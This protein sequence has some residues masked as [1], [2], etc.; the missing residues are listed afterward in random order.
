MGLYFDDV[1]TDKSEEI[2]RLHDL[3]RV[4]IPNTI[5]NKVEALTDE[6]RRMINNHTIYARDAVRAVY[7]FPY[8]GRLLE[9]Y[10][11]IALYH[12]E[13]YDGTGYPEGLAGE[14][15]PYEAR[16]CAVADVY[17]GITSWKPYK[18]KQTT[19]EQAGEIILSEAGRQFDPQLAEL[20]VKMI[21]RL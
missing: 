19:K 13:R 16:I 15:I 20:F 4:Y 21:P 2:F 9:Q 8:E 12:H 7:D 17:D 6:E 14:Y 11:N 5:L 10:L 18:T 3:G 1:F